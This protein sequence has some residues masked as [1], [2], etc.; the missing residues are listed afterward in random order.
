M[1]EA[2]KLVNLFSVYLQG[3][4]RSWL[5]EPDAHDQYAV[6]HSGGKYVSIFKNTPF[7]AQQITARAVSGGGGG[8]ERWT[9]Y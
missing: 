1:F 9:L 3:N 4:L 6:I 8:G 7:E 2:T 5:L